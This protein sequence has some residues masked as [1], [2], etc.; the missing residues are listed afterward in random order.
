MRRQDG[1]DRSSNVPPERAAEDH[2]DD[3]GGG[4]DGEP[5]CVGADVAGEL[6][7][8]QRAE[9]LGGGGGDGAGAFD[10]AGVED[11]LGDAA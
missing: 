11:E 8:D 10:E 5:S 2:D 1:V 4:A 9:A 6:P 7:A 3:D